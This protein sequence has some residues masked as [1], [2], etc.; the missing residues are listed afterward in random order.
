VAASDRAATVN[1]SLRLPELDV[2]V[3]LTLDNIF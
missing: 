3:T 2:R 1:R